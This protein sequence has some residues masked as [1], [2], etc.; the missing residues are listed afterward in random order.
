MRNNLTTASNTQVSIALNMLRNGFDSVS[1]NH[2]ISELEKHFLNE[3]GYM[4]CLP[5]EELLSYGF[6]K[7]R[8]FAHVHAIYQFP[9]IELLDVLSN[10]IGKNSCIE[11]GAGRGD[12]GRLLNIKMTDSHQ[13]SKPQYKQHYEMINQPLIKYPKDVEKIG[14]K[15]AIKKYRPEIVLGCWVTHRYDPQ[16]P[17]AKGNIEGIDTNFVTQRAKKFIFVGNS[18]IH[19]NWTLPNYSQQH[20]YTF[21]GIVSRAAQGTN[22]VAVFEKIK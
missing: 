12:I 20:A 15:D 9:T 4:K 18:K 2:D 21:E 10:M 19:E 13:Q 22:F 5:A 7:L 11:I 1:A 14:Y 8:V 16:R 3:N 6:E 17:E